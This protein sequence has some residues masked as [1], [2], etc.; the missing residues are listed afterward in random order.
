MLKKKD[1]YLLMVLN[2]VRQSQDACSYFTCSQVQYFLVFFNLCSEVA[3]IAE[4]HFTF[5][6]WYQMLI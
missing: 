1:A 3:T 6:L 2:W 5:I 4:L